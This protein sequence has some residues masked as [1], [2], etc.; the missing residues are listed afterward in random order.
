[1]EDSF[2]I[3][4]CFLQEICIKKQPTNEKDEILKPTFFTIL[5]KSA[6]LANCEEDF[7]YY[8]LYSLFLRVV[9]NTLSLWRLLGLRLLCKLGRTKISLF[10]IRLSPYGHCHSE[11]FLCPLSSAFNIFRLTRKE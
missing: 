6:L 9:T 8:T 1:M 7:F 4:C 2:Q 3:I 10:F 5:V 11:A